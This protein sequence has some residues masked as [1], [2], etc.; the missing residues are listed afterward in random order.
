MR[1]A[2]I[3]KTLCA[4]NRHAPP[5]FLIFFSASLVKNLALT[6]RGYSGSSPL[7]RTLKMPF[8]VTSSTGAF[9]ASAPAAFAASYVSSGS[10]DQS[11]SMLTV[12]QW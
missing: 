5:L 4:V 10:I 1:R 7:P 11:L 9:F 12:G 2:E 6:M 3:V 8:F